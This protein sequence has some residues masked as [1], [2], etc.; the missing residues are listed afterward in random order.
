MGM[1]CGMVIA[2]ENTDNSNREE[3]MSGGRQLRENRETNL[4]RAKG[5]AKVGVGLS[6]PFLPKDN[7]YFQTGD[8]N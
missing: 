7:V 2:A 8:G 6:L 4:Q 5:S 1:F 3:T